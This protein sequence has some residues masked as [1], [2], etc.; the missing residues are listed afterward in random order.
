V[1]WGQQFSIYRTRLLDEIAPEHF[2]TVFNAGLQL[3][4]QHGAL[5]R[6]EV[7]GGYHLVALDGV[8]Y[9]L[10]FIGQDDEPGG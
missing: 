3:A 8:W 7:L 9:Y 4:E 10:D 2:S 6:Y 1:V 5:D